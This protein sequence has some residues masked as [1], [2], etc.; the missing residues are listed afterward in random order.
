MRSLKIGLHGT[1]IALAVAGGYLLAQ[2]GWGVGSTTAGA[3]PSAQAS[4]A[5]PVP[6]VGV[7]KKTIPIYLEYFARTE[8]VRNITLQAKVSGYLQEQ[9]GRGR[10]GCKR[11][12][13]CSTK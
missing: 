5:M 6:V 1:V 4:Q 7:V 10:H 13:T 8:A 2:N 12:A 9:P 11:R 3:A